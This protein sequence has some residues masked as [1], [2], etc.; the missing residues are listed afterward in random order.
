MILTIL[1]YPDPVLREAARPVERI[2][3]G[4]RAL[5]TDMLETMRAAEGVGLAAPQVGVGLRLAVV[6][7]N[8]EGGDDARALVNPVV[9]RRSRDRGTA[10]E[11]CLSFP[12]VRTK[13]KRAARVTV[14]YQDM[15]GAEREAEVEG[16][17][18]RA[19]QHELDHLDGVLFV[20]KADRAGKAAV[21]DELAAMEEAFALA[22]AG[23]KS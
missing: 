23:G 1:R 5:A 22:P 7:F 17:A 8:P 9:V 19:V 6:E 4:L 18:A 3:A 2:D 21:R 15:D 20:D 16:L 12:G 14:S 11:G 10:D 13:I